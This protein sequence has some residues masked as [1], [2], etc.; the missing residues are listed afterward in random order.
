MSNANDKRPNCPTCGAPGTV[1]RSE[2]VGKRSRRRTYGCRACEIRI[3]DNFDPENVNDVTLSDIERHSIGSALS[4][5]A[6]GHTVGSSESN[7]VVL[8]LGSMLTATPLSREQ[9]AQRYGVDGRT[10]DRWRDSRDFPAP[11]VAG[12][13]AR[14]SLAQLIEWET[15]VA[16]VEIFVGGSPLF[17]RA[18]EIS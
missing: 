13:S 7:Q 4:D 5:A 3:S 12:R 2:R 8:E 1:V 16:G 10:L 6:S 17:N 11:F 15:R 9:V 14:W 18:P